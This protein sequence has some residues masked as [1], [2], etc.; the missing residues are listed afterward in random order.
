MRQQRSALRANDTSSL[1]PDA[2]RACDAL[3]TARLHPS[4]ATVAASSSRAW[5]RGE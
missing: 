3:H 5:L 1:L 4:R 2:Q